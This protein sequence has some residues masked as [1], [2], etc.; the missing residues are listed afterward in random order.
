MRG[1]AGEPLRPL[2]R[3]SDRG[4]R[5]VALWHIPRRAGA[6]RVFLVHRRRSRVRGPTVVQLLTNSTAGLAP[7]ECDLRSSPLLLRTC[8]HTTASLAIHG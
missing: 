2:H 6:R 8:F 3:P 7:R 5:A 1:R 4:Y